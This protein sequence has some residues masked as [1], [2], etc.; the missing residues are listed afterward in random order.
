M[1]NKNNSLTEG[2]ILS[3]L[4]KMALPIMGTSFLQMAYNLTD[5]IWIGRVGSSSVA[6]VGTAGF[7]IWLSFSLIMISKTGAEV[8]VAQGIGSQRFS[9]ARNAA[10]SALQL[11]F[12][13][14]LIYGVLILLFK[15]PMIRFFNIPDPAVND[16]AISYLSII[17]YG[18]VFMFSPPVFSAIFNGS[19]DSR[20]PFRINTIG[21]IANMILDPLLIFGLGPVPALGVNGA[22]IATIASQAIVT[23]VFL[24]ELQT[25]KTAFGHVNFLRKPNFDHINRI[26]KMGLPTACN[27]ALFT[28]FSMVLARIIA[29]WGPLPI[30]VQKVG[31][32]IESIS[33]MTASGFSVAIS[34]FF[35][36]NFG[37]G[38]W[39]RLWKGYSTSLRI[40]L[41]LGAFNTL[42]LILGAAP[43]FAIF[44]PEADAIRLGIDYLQ[45]LGV[46]QL[47]MCIEITTA[48]AF[49][50]L[51]KTMP[52]SIVSIAFNALRIP[53]ALY[54]SQ[55]EV[56]G[57]NGVWW[58][59]TISSIF[60]G[61]ILVIWYQF[62]IRKYPEM[63]YY[64]STL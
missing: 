22:A 36:Q 58:S 59:I 45:I 46:S 2:H 39:D 9:D 28:F 3:A 53:M 38:N 15:D 44:I 60:K 20:T 48:G 25:N 16:M 41:I 33:W 10:R 1:N 32:Q 26:V 61:V 64:R 23:L 27:S 47:F 50:G 19:G 6:A 57:L 24:V 18:T 4:V 30:A 56:W 17:G 5:M 35:G 13:M 49:N 29:Q 11:N 8:L 21:L 54:F 31:S 42:L 55:P 37:A 43:I 7:Y 40:A 34:A 63:Q 52:P 62:H 12:V 51:G 14:A